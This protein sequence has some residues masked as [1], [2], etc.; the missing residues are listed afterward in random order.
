MGRW[1]TCEPA[2]GL[3]LTAGMVGITHSL[4]L[5]LNSGESRLAATQT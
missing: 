3:S 2:M 4:L 1:F 5:P